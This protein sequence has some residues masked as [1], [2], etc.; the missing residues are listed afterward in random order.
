MAKKSLIEHKKG[1]GMGCVYMSC[2][3]MSWG[4]G[5]GKTQEEVE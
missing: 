5:F 3:V 4:W 1:L 2:H